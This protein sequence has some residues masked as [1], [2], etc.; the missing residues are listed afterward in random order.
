MSQHQITVTT[1]DGHELSFGCSDDCDVVSAAEQADIKL[2]SLCRDGACGACVGHC[3]SGQYALGRINN[4]VLSDEAVAKGEVLLCRTYPKQD[5]HI[6]T[7]Y[8]Y[9]HIR[10]GKQSVRQATISQLEKV[11]ER[12]VRLKLSLIE[13]GTGMAVEF[14]PGQCMELEI[15]GTEIRRAYSLANTGNWQGELEFLIRLQPEGRF[16]TYLG[17]Q[18]EIGQV[19]TVYG[20]DGAFGLQADSFSPAIF[21]AGGTGLAPFLS[22]LR[23]MVEWGEDRS[24]HL[25]FGVNQENELFCVEQLKNLQAQLPGL[26]FTLCVW[27]P[28]E[29]WNDGFHGTPVDALR[30]YLSDKPDD[31]DVYLCGPPLLVKAASEAAISQGIHERRIYSEKFG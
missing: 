22:I 3:D 23:R 29:N 31:Y 17:Q 28:S 15:P 16:S 27:K 20:P 26:T 21:I 13:D 19:L 10:F 24:I 4:T 25:L 30:Q 7:P 2:P 1:R 6:S 18:A 9:A 11:A 14:E 8:D 5:L 12:T